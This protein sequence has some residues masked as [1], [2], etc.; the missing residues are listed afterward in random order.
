MAQPVYPQAS[1]IAPLFL[2]LRFVPQLGIGGGAECAG[3]G[4]KAALDV[5]QAISARWGVSLRFWMGIMRSFWLGHLTALAL[6][7]CSGAAACLAG[8][9]DDARSAYF[10]K[11]YASALGLLRPLADLGNAEAQRM[12]GILYENGLAVPPDGRQAVE[13]YR[14]AAAQHD[15]EAE[16]RLGIR[17]LDGVDGLPHD[18]AQGIALMEMAGEHGNLR[19]FDMLG[20][21]YRSGVG[22]VSK[23]AV[24]SAAWYRRA[25]ELGYADSQAALGAAYQYGQ[26]VPRDIHQAIAW[27]RKAADQ[28]NSGAE[29]ALARIYARGDDGEPNRQAALCWYWKV[30]RQI[31]D[32]LAKDRLDKTRL[33]G[34]HLDKALA[35]LAIAPLGAQSQ[36]PSD[37]DE[38]QCP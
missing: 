34:D 5:Q 21:E 24:K 19:S 17:F 20:L 35:D 1:E 22:G 6:M 18:V 33:A 26:G 36:S 3:H 15:P 28:D 23:D 29:I 4:Q 16:Y 32:D 14:K 10:N 37:A 38:K 27:Y 13:L 12:V 25:A 7:T 2:N 31:N 30:V 11:D 8:P 9:L